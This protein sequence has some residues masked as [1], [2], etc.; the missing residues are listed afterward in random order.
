MDL[1]PFREL[2]LRQ[3]RGQVHYSVTDVERMAKR[4]DHLPWR[5]LERSGPN[6]E[7]VPFFLGSIRVTPG[8]DSSGALLR[9]TRC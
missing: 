3:K 7:P 1:S 5:C 9:S 6:T 8:C 2:V 4:S